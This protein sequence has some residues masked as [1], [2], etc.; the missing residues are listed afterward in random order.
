MY[1]I[2]RTSTFK[3]DY[4]KLNNSEKSLLKEIITKLVNVEE[5]EEK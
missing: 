3:K 1:E 2:F 4:K 5:L